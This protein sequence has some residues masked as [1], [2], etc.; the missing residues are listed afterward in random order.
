[1]SNSLLFE[2]KL[3]W[4]GLL[5]EPNPTA[6]E[7]LLKKHRKAWSINVCLSNGPFPEV[8]QFDADGLTGA[9]VQ[10]GVNFQGVSSLSLHHRDKDLVC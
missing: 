4:S 6:F 7:L 8:I 2:T 1:M 10:L 3:G 9:I 5:I